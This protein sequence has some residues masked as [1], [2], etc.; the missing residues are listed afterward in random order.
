MN[1]AHPQQVVKYSVIAGEHVL[2]SGLS[3]PEAVKMAEREAYYMDV[4]AASMHDM[5][6]IRVFVADEF[7]DSVAEF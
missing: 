7:G 1:N 5:R 3:L 4:Y 2:A 6:G